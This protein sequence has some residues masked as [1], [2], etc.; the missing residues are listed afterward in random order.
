MITAKSQLW[1]N[2]NDLRGDSLPCTKKIPSI[3]LYF[4]EKYVKVNTLSGTT[5]Y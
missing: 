1:V 3:K 5:E 4:T 2:L